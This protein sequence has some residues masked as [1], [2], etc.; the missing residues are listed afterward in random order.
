MYASLNLSLS[1]SGVTQ[2]QLLLDIIGFVNRG[3]VEQEDSMDVMFEKAVS[4]LP[5]AFS[6]LFSGELDKQTQRIVKDTKLIDAVFNMGLAPYLRA[7]DPF[8]DA[9]AMVSARGVQKLVHVALQRICSNIAE[10]QVGWGQIR[11][12]WLTFRLHQIRSS[13]AMCSTHRPLANPGS[14]DPPSITTCHH[15]QFYFVHRTTPGGQSWF[16]TLVSQLEA[17]L[18]PA[19]TLAHLLTS[20]QALQRECVTPELI[21]RFV[22][23]VFEHGPQPR[24]L[25]FFAAISEVNGMPQ[26]ENQEMI[27]RKVN[28]I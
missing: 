6:A 23:M 18:G 19:V 8:G 28:L 4:M 24:F 26:E 15:Y 20:N 21:Q 22:S 11:F 2:V 16:E 27:L 9:S 17:P 5:S 25:N 10:N 3:E 13:E 14:N 7:A 1:P 12:D